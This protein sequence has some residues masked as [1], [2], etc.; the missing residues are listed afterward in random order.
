MSVQQM[1]ERVAALMEERLGVGGRGLAAKLDRGGRQLPKKIRAEARLLAEAAGLA[2][3]PKLTA[4]LD[5]A[6]VAAAYDA[7]VKYLAPLGRGDR[8]RAL[9]R[10][11]AGQIVAG[12]I[13][14]F[15]LVVTVLVLRGYL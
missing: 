13:L 14:T 12:L 7:C 11:I 6:R 1:A 10:G 4:T 2:H 3:Q 9:F 15:V 5:H 8:R